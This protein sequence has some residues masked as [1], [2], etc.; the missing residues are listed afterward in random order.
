MTVLIGIF[1]LWCIAAYALHTM[2]T[3]MA[4]AMFS[5]NPSRWEREQMRRMICA[6]PVAPFFW[7]I[8]IARAVRKYGAR[9]GGE[10]EAG[11]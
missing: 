3:L 2:G 10:G 11:R 1:I 6:W 5:G 8:V 9:E 7:P 4:L